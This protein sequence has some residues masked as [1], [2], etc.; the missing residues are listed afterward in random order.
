ML[1]FTHKAENILR[2]EVR[3]QLSAADLRAYYAEI[4]ASYRQHGKLELFVTATDFRGYAGLGAL[5]LF[6]RH[7][8]GLLW[9]VRSYS[10]Q[11]GPFWFR[12]LVLLLGHLVPWI[13]VK[14]RG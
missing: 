1:R 6:L 14:V 8:P 10:L 7:E 5:F 2:Y 12:K 3:D 13:G 4:D 11:G 9:K